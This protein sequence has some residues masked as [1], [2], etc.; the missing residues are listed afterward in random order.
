MFLVTGYTNYGKRPAKVFKKYY[1][2]IHILQ[3][4]AVISNVQI[5]KPVVLSSDKYFIKKL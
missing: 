5:Y 2:V 3:V 4:N 1:W